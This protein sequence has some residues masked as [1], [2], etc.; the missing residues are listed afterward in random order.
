MAAMI[1]PGIGQPLQQS[2]FAMQGFPIGDHCWSV[3]AVLV[4][5]Y[6][7][8]CLPLI[9]ISRGRQMLREFHAIRI[10]MVWACFTF[11]GELLEAPP[12]PLT[13]V[14]T[15]WMGFP[16]FVHHSRTDSPLQFGQSCNCVL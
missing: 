13:A 6:W 8:R 9:L 12:P 10:A 1:V 3:S 16:P 7:Q 14:I 5:Y 2:Q 4:T 15:Y 11:L